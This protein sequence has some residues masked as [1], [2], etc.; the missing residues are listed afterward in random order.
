MAAGGTEKPSGGVVNSC[1]HGSLC[2]T[3][4]TTLSLRNTEY[5]SPVV[6]AVV[7]KSAETGGG[8]SCRISNAG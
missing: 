5:W 8:D 4:T 3:S 6:S 1:C 7:T 2:S